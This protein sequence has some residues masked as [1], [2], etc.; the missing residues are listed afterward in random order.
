MV[1]TV[2]SLMSNLMADI[3]RLMF[4]ADPTAASS[5]ANRACHLNIFLLKVP[6]YINF[7]ATSSFIQVLLTAIHVNREMGSIATAK[8]RVKIE[9]KY[10]PSSSVVILK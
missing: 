4:P 1:H 10:Y 7:V 9:I 5:T 6:E 8:L 3:P 2:R